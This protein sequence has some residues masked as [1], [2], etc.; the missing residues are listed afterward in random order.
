MCIVTHF[1]LS[2]VEILQRIRK[3]FKHDKICRKTKQ[4]APKCNMPKEFPGKFWDYF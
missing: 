3:N 4:S 1:Q 2:H